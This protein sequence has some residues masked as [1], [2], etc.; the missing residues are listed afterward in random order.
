MFNFFLFSFIIY[1]FYKK[2]IVTGKLQSGMRRALP[3][4]IAYLQNLVD[5]LDGSTR[6]DYNKSRRYNSDRHRY[7]HATMSIEEA[8]QILGVKSTASKEEIMQAFKK[9]MMVNHPDKGGSEYI[10]AKIIQA[11]KTLIQH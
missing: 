8:C 9:L 5:K 10:A 7:G 11:K 3:S 1:Y 6:S 4:V 2:T